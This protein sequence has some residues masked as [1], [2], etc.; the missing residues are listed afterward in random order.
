VKMEEIIILMNRFLIPHKK[1]IIKSAMMMKTFSK[2]HNLN[3]DLKNTEK[4]AIIKNM[5]MK[6][7]A[8]KIQSII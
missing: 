2:A 8:M 6:K 1:I 5:I 7:S 3:L 4:K